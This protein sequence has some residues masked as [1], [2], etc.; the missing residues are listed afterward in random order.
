M[1]PIFPLFVDATLQG[2]V[3]SIENKRLTGMKR[4]VVLNDSSELDNVLCIGRFV[5]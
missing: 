4:N 1:K 3:Q 2:I 5:D